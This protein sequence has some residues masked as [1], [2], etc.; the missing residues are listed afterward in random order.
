MQYQQISDYGTANPI[1]ARLSI[2][3]QQLLQFYDLTDKQKGEIFSLMFSD[4]QPKLLACFTVADRLQKEVAEHQQKIKEGKIEVQGSAYKIPSVF[5]LRTDAENFLYQA[6]S[7]LR[8]L[9]RLFL[10]YF[11]K[12]S[13]IRLASI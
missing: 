11:R 13:T 3:T 4:I 9:T 6:K 7:V 10:S 12:T 2:Q 5:N 1:V 8:D